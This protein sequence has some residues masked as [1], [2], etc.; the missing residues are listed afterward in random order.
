M[1]VLLVC[2]SRCVSSSGLK[3]DH[4]GRYGPE[5][6]FC[7]CF[8]RRRLGSGM[9]CLVTLVR[10]SPRVVFPLVV[11]RPEILCMTAGMDPMDR[12]AAR[13]SLIVASCKAGTAGC[14]RRSLLWLAGPRCSASWPVW[15]RMTVTWCV[16]FKVVD[17][18]VMV[19]RSIPMFWTVQQNIEFPSCS[20]TRWSMPLYC[21]WCEF[22]RCC[23]EKTVVFPQLHLPRNLAC[24]WSPVLGQGGG[25]AR[26][27]GRQA[28]G[29]VSAGTVELSLIS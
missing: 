16:L 17:I 22:H 29:A 15:I 1:L 19:Q 5:G 2:S 21:W 27:G 18:P 25:R 13:C 28:R 7:A 6:H 12:Y 20:W 10:R 9:C 4:H 24:T 8:A 11:A 26:C 14:I 3:R 23:C